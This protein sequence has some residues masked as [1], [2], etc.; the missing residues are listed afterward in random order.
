[1]KALMWL[2]TIMDALN[3]ILQ[4]LNNPAVISSIITA[5][6]GVISI[7]ITNLY[8]AH[9]N[10]I[11]RQEMEKRIEKMQKDLVDMGLEME[12]K[13]RIQRQQDDDER[14]KREDKHS[15]EIIIRTNQEYARIYLDRLREDPHIAQFQ[16]LDMPRPLKIN[17][18]YVPT[19][20]H[21]N[22]RVS[23][24]LDETLYEAERHRNP[25]L[26][27]GQELAFLEKRAGSTLTSLDA[28][29]QF[30]RCV[31]VGDPGAGK[32]TLLKYLALQSAA[33]Q[34]GMPGFPIFAELHAFAISHHADLLAFVA[35][36]WEESYGFPSP[37]AQVYMKEMLT[38]GKAVLLLDAL[39]ETMIG[40]TEKEAKDSYH[41]VVEAI[42]HI[43]SRYPLTPIVVTA[44]KAG[45]Q[46]QETLVGFS[47]FE[48]MPF[49]ADDT[50]Q[51]I[52]KWFDGYNDPQKQALAGDLTIQLQRT[53]H[54]QALAT[55]PL[56][57]ALIV[58]VYEAQLRLPERRAELYRECVDILLKEWDASRYIRRYSEFKREHKLQLLEEIAWHFHQ[59]GRRYFPKDELLKRIARFLPAVQLASEENERVLAEITNEHG[60]LKEQARNL[61]GFIHLTF[62]EYFVALYLI[63][64]SKRSILLEYRGN[65]WWEEVFFLYTGRIADASRLLSTLLGQ[66]AIACP[67]DIF[68]TNLILAGRCLAAGPTLRQASLWKTVVD[69]LK[70]E[71]LTTPYVLMMERL[72]QTLVSIGGKDI[73]TWLLNLLLDEQLEQSLRTSVA[74]ALGMRGGQDIVQ[75]LR[76]HFRNLHINPVV[77]SSIVQALGMLEERSLIPHWLNMLREN[78]VD[79]NV[80]EGIVQALGILGGPEIV[81]EFVQLLG[82][83]E[84]D[85]YIRGRIAQVLSIM[86]DRSIVPD[87]LALLKKRE[88]IY[89]Q[90]TSEIT[91]LIQIVRTVGVLGERAIAPALLELLHN[92]QLDISLR[93]QIVQVLGTLDDEDVVANLKHLL[94]HIQL[95]FSVMYA[96][97]L[98][99]CLA[100]SAQDMLHLLSEHSFE[101]VVPSLI[102]QTLGVQG[103]RSIAPDLLSF[104]EKKDTDLEPYVRGQIIQVLGLL[105]ERTVLPRLL[106]LL[107][108]Q[109]Q[110]DKLIRSNIALILRHFAKSITSDEIIQ[111]TQ[112]LDSSDVASD[113]YS[114]LWTISRQ[115]R[116]RIYL[117]NEQEQSVV[118]I[119][120][121][122]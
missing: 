122:K 17:A 8:Q 28:I 13:A 72:A 15:K 18:I 75:G 56:L 102:V 49:R 45:Y 47:E 1:V 35:F 41:R 66:D 21:H 120:E 20:L 109:H 112:L 37:N 79:W 62:Q 33:Q 73:N 91:M 95:R 92:Q 99:R 98:Q 39:D 85:F 71:M 107:T 50:R 57:L 43:A 60:F 101:Q 26:L 104:L 29:H 108:Y 44:R 77:R 22:A 117:L 84:I 76:H 69:Q 5:I 65:P 68:Y 80:G 24:E 116:I 55:N 83:Q 70:K 2:N 6:F 34:T 64:R 106:D 27:I 53:P 105:G 93:G 16:I 67:E 96:L 100:M 12:R 42:K 81:H 40:N 3:A 86:G 48:L 87:L 14:K 30:K 32:T 36:R 10:R 4:L 121:I 89:T 9:H 103:D 38:A 7:I 58:R 78:S 51:F 52:K 31:L 82:K 90:S 11:E 115:R 94:S 19:L 88:V 74:L 111:L 114:T 46:Q 25:D 113:I 97:A 119:E 54:I 59:Q 23:Y 110:K 118:R 61:Y 63:D